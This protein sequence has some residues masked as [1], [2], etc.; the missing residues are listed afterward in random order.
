MIQSGK[1]Y[2]PFYN[3]ISNPMIKCRK[4]LE[5]TRTVALFVGSAENNHCV[6]HFYLILVPFLSISIIPSWYFHNLKSISGRKQILVLILDDGDNGGYFIG[7]SDF[8]L[9]NRSDKL[10]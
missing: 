8:L 2:F 5:I 3:L 1:V 10:I 4:F 7:F 6:F 9:I